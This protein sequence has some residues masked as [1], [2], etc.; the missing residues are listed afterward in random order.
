MEKKIQLTRGSQ[1]FPYSV[2]IDKGH[3]SSL[4]VIVETTNIDID[5]LGTFQYEHDSAETTFIAMVDESTG[6]AITKTITA[7]T[8]AGKMLKDCF[9]RFVKIIFSVPGTAVMPTVAT[10]ASSDV[11]ATGATVSAT[12]DPKLSATVVTFEVGTTTDYELEPVVVEAAIAKDAGATAV[13]GAI[14]EL[15][16]ETDYHWRVKMVNS[17]GT[18]YSDDQTF[19][20]I[21][22]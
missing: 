22:E 2:I 7:G 21:A 15:T 9:A 1:D 11:I 17:V 8:K 10:P 4:S 6:D 18:S 5:I 19:T 20:T 14:A 13:T 12:V 3:D 16:P